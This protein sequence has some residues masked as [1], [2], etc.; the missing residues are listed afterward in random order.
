[1]SI[2]RVLWDHWFLASLDLHS[3]VI[4]SNVGFNQIILGDSDVVIKMLSDSKQIDEAFRGAIL[5]LKDGQECWN[6]ERLW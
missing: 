1:M 2:L 3:E 4:V 6:Q 5:P